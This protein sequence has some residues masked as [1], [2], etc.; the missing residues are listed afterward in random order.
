MR[1]WTGVR[2][3]NGGLG[4]GSVAIRND[5]RDKPVKDHP[6]VGQASSI[7]LMAERTRR[8]GHRVAVDEQDG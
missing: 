6:G 7:P 8:V 3:I 1:A 4:R 2:N 5:Q